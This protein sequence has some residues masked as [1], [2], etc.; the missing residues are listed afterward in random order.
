[1]SSVGSDRTGALEPHR[2]HGM[3]TPT[4]RSGPRV[5]RLHPAPPLIGLADFNQ[6]LL[7]S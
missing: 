7:L 5:Q 6:G 4:G 2:V 3:Q 1:M